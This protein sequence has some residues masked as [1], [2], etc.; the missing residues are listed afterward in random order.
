MSYSENT[1]DRL[2]AIDGI[3]AGNFLYKL[4]EL[5]I[6]LEEDIVTLDL[7]LRGF[8]SER[9]LSVN[10]LD[11]LSDLYARWF[12]EKGITSKDTVAIY[13]EEGIDYFVLYL[14]LT[15]IGAI[16]VMVNSDLPK[17]VVVPFFNYIETVAIVA[18]DIR[19]YE[20]SSFVLESGVDTKLLNIDAVRYP[21]D[22]ISDIDVLPVVPYKHYD[23]DPVLLSHTSGTTGVPKAVRFSHSSMFYGF[24]KQIK[25]QIGERVLSALPHS[26]SSSVGLLMSAFMRGN[27][28]RIQTKRDKYDLEQASKS[29][30]PDL[31]VAFPKTFIEL[32]RHELNAKSFESINYWL[33]TGDANHE[34]HIR[35][36]VKLGKH[37]IG[38]KYYAGSLFVDNLGSTEFA[39]SVFVNVH[40]PHSNNYKR[41]IGKP[42][43]WVDV[44]VL[45]E[46]A[47]ELGDYQVGKLGVHSESVTP[48]YWN[49]SL[50]TEKSKLG[51]YWL[52]GDLVYRNSAGI[53]YH[54]D[55]IQDSIEYRGKKLYS[56]Q[57]E[58]LIMSNISDV[59]DCSLVCAESTKGNAQLYL[60]V[61]CN[62]AKC[63]EE[64]LISE[65]NTLL[66]EN[67][68]PCLYKLIFESASS[69]MGVTGK[70]L[71]R[72]LRV[73]LQDTDHSLNET[74]A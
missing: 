44:A 30:Q 58:E 55:R 47:V 2:L 23:C 1:I 73:N 38:K 22:R 46:N 43:E 33:S 7:P 74:M 49:K 17:D 36:L 31:F 8:T 25:K 37:R 56:C 19:E 13:L 62:H 45:S 21:W 18:D 69:N 16:P 32:C 48:G 65:I 41:C 28:I 6:D 14:S 70:K 50:L 60:T 51:K 10:S 40:T 61:D 42:M 35:R 64:T 26:H 20:L 11:K 3:G 12:L 53:Y 63:D 52:L 15:K 39:F 72:K 27:K 34:S 4:K 57:V 29:Y 59:F 9:A 67:N 66:V 71:K 5:D 68:L 54:V 24:K